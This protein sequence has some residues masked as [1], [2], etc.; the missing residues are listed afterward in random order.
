MSESGINLD[1][2]PGVLQ[3]THQQISEEP[4]TT[5]A[6]P[7]STKHGNKSPACRNAEEKLPQNFV[8]SRAIPPTV[9]PEAFEQIAEHARLFADLR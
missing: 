7:E 1:Q 9:T 4:R 3:D 5:D 6:Q 8:W 2:G